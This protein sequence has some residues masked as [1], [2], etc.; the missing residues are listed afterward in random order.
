MSRELDVSLHPAQLEIFNSTA[1]FKE[2]EDETI[3]KLARSA[4][5]RLE[6]E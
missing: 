5:E 1:R 4:S 6:G 2:E 3:V